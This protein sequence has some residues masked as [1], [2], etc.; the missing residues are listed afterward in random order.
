MLFDIS[1]MTGVEERKGKMRQIILQVNNNIRESL[2]FF[3]F[4]EQRE[5]N[6]SLIHLKVSTFL[7]R[8]QKMV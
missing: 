5:K 1:N 6:E 7:S 2:V 4:N 3:S 8:I